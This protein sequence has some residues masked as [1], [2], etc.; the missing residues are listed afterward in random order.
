MANGLIRTEAIV[1]R[2]YR[3]AE[4]DKIVVALG[5]DTGMVRGVARGARRLKNRFGAGLE[6]W[7]VI[8]LEFFAKEQ[9]ELVSLRAAE[10]IITSFKLA[11]H[12]EAVTTLDYLSDLLIAFVP[13]GEPNPKVYRMAK[14]CLL[15]LQ[16]APEKSILLSR[17]FELWL[18]KLSGFL[19]NFILCQ[20]CGRDFDLKRK[21]AFGAQGTLVCLDCSERAA[22][23]L[24]VEGLRELHLMRRSAPEKY[25]QQYSAGANAEVGEWTRGI[26]ERVLERPFE[27]KTQVRD[28]RQ[29]TRWEASVR[30]E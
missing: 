1:L 17:Y 11:T 9:R 21:A 2:T 22:F 27:D 3:L 16:N 28:F 12:D 6:I 8:N 19:P 23:Y 24:S 20:R 10:I 30:T 25:L 7:T 5:V 4:A 15:A 18:L 14:S 26:I 29:A 13:P